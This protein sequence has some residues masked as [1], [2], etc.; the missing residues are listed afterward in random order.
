MRLG[1]KKNPDVSDI[2]WLLPNTIEKWETKIP[3]VGETIPIWAESAI[4]ALRAMGRDDLVNQVNYEAIY[5]AF[6]VSY[7]DLYKMV[8]PLTKN[9]ISL[10]ANAFMGI[11]RRYFNA[12]S[13]F[14]RSRVNLDDQSKAR[15]ITINEAVA[16]L[17]SDVS[18][19]K[20]IEIH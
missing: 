12:L 6:V 13:R 15:Y 1:K 20:C 7:P 18:L 17:E 14:V 10:F 11:L 8:L 16:F 5:K 3:C 19:F 9:K 2:P 4:K